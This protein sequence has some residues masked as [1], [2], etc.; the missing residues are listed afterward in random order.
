MDREDQRADL[1][2]LIHNAA[3]DSGVWLT[4]VHRLADVLRAQVG[5]IST[6]DAQTG[7]IT[8]IK[9]RM[10]P[11]ALH[12]YAGRWRYRN[13]LIAPA[14]RRP[15]GSVVRVVNPLVEADWLPRRRPA[16]MRFVS[17]PERIDAPTAAVR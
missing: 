12:D 10:T 17:D 5:Q 3:V 1:V 8:H 7:T 13:P 11:E 14:R 9:P 6:F 4:V 15:T 16:A 2:A